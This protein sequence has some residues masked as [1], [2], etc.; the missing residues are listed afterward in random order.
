METSVREYEVRC[1]MKK[2]NAMRLLDKEKIDYRVSQYPVDESDLSAVHAAE[3]L[4]A[5]IKQV[6]KTL[7][8]QGKSGGYM[9]AC[10]Q[11]DAAIDLK[12]LAK[13]AGE[14]NV[15]MIKQKDLQGLTGYMRGGVSP[16]GMKK[17]YPTFLDETMFSQT[18]IYFSAG[19]R[20]KQIILAP[21][22]L[23]KMVDGVSGDIQED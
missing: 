9:V 6:Y 19:E 3:A 17:K 15:E 4:G 8:L 23:K 21:E 13:I 20:G 7:V 1:T 16:L 18:E 11:G 22:L 14:K 12:K 5:D 2:T 10:I